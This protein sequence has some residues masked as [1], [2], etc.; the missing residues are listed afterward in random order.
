M[1]PN[2]R[3]KSESRY[4]RDEGFTDCSNDASRRRDGTEEGVLGESGG[5][6][7]QICEAADF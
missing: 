6:K 3:G 5:G 4:L 2:L 7:R 1:L